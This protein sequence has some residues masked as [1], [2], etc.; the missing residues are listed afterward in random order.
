MPGD[1]P[2]RLL[3]RL[4]PGGFR[5]LMEKGAWFPDCR[6]LA[7]AFPAS[8]IATLA[9]G[10]WPAQHGIVAG[11]W[12]DRAAQKPVTASEEA[13]LA[14]TLAA[15][16]TSQQM[17]VYVVGLDAWQ[18]RLFA[19]TAEASRFW[20]AD[21]GHFQMLGEP[22][23]WLEE[24]NQQRSLEGV[25]DAKWQAVGARPD[26][27]ALRILNYSPQRPREFVALYRS[28][29]FA[30]NAQLDFAAELIAR[31]GLGTQG[32]TDFLCIVLGSSALLGYETGSRDPLM[33]Q[34]VLQLDRRLEML[35]AQLTKSVGDRGFNFALACA[36]GVPPKPAPETA[37]RMVVSGESVAQEVERAL[38]STGSGRVEKYL[39][40]FLYLDTS[41]FRD[42]E[43]LRQ[44]AARAALRHPAVADYYTAGGGTSSHDE[45]ARRFRNSFHATRSG[46]VMLSY[47]PEYVEDFGQGRGISYGSVY[48]YDIQTPLFFY[49]PQFRP[50]V[51]VRAAES[52]DLAPT[53]ARVLGAAEPSSSV[54]RVL[55]EALAR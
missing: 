46:D 29:P 10:A 45:W 13:L 6:H 40:P 36:H 26:A 37:A 14:T 43:P 52:V 51:Y 48:N 22:L 34:I 31:E 20:M 50:G 39:Y 28:S 5:R 30:Q 25:H 27:P 47:R 49:G 15:Q 38:V 41:G 55:A 19:G 11:S 8:S 53:L 44:I 42:P 35:L 9:T 18:S 24:Y 32:A 12:Y 33:E 23:D 2:E 7:S 54:G 4:S 21:D 3:P 16:L 1:L 17:K